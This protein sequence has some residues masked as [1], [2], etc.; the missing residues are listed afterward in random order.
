L[1]RVTPHPKTAELLRKLGA[2]DNPPTKPVGRCVEGRFGLE[3]AVVKPGTKEPPKEAPKDA[4]N[5]APDEV[6]PQQ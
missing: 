2:I 1:Q 5:Q 3:Y 4:P 6:P